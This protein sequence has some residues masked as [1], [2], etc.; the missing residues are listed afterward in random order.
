MVI[1]ILINYF[2]SNFIVHIVAVKVDLFQKSFSLNKYF[3]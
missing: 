3:I 2:S 1:L